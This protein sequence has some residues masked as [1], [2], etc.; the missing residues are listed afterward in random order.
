MSPPTSRQN[1]FKNMMR[2]LLRI[3]LGDNHFNFNDHFYNQVSGVAMGTRCA[4]HF[5]NLFMASLEERALNSWTGTQPKLWLRFLDDV[6]MLWRSTREE[7][8]RFHHHLNQQMA[9]I[10]FTMECSLDKAIFLDLQ[11]TKG[12]RFSEK[13]ILD[14]SLHIK[15]TNPLN[16][17]HYS[18]CHPPAT[19]STIVRGEI[20]RALRCTSSITTYTTILDKLLRKFKSRGY[21]EWLLRQEADRINYSCREEIM[22]PSPKRTLEEDVAFFSATFSPAISS[23]SIRKALTDKDTPFTPMVLRPRPT[24]IQERL[25]RAKVGHPAD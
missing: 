18:S 7:L 2:D 9:S 17:L 19:F 10:N 1:N 4:P 13:K 25:V 20:M 24:S 11:I 21:P 5:A 16:F 6:F 23:S 15:D 8:D 12:S 22:Q 3:T 14:V